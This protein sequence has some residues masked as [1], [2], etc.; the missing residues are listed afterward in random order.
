MVIII[1]IHTI[2]TD[3]IHMLIN[4]CITPPPPNLERVIVIVINKEPK[5]FIGR[6]INM[7]L[8]NGLSLRNQCIE[9]Q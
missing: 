1:D 4:E 7:I 6:V 3:Y 9:E 5:W 8:L 2:I